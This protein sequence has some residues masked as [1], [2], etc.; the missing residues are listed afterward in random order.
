M[1]SLDDPRRGRVPLEI[2]LL[3]EL[4]V[5]R[6]GKALALPASR[7]SRALLAYLVATGK[8]QP[9]AHLSELFWGDADDPRAALRWSLNKLRP[10]VDEPG[11]VR[12]LSEG[13]HVAFVRDGAVIDLSTLHEKIGADCSRASTEALAAAVQCFRGE[14][15]EGLELPGCYRYHAWCVAERERLRTLRTSMLALL[16]ERLRD[17]RTAGLP[18]DPDVTLH[19]SA[20]LLALGLLGSRWPGRRSDHHRCREDDRQPARAPL[21]HVS[22]VDSCTTRHSPPASSPRKYDSSLM[23]PGSASREIT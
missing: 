19:P 5:R 18:D 9:R 16:A 14:F 22:E 8:T 4:E 3:G 13:D 15:L 10:L 23:S 17:R 11:V 1:G 6:T 12:L 2:G 21:H 20:D 7:K